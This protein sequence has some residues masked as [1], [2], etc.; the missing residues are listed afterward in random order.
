MKSI[1]FSLA[2]AATLLLVPLGCGDT[3]TVVVEPLYV[4]NWAPTQGSLCVD[5]DATL[6]VTF[7]DDIDVA[8]LQNGV[9]LRDA[10][11]EVAGV[12]DYSKQTF[13]ASYA[14][15]AAMAFDALYTLTLAPSLRGARLG[16]LGVALTSS[17]RTVARQGCSPGI[18]CQLPSDC[19]DGEICSN[20]GTCIAECVTDLDCQQGTCVDGSCVVN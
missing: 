8:T 20:I 16:D 4:V 12:I 15:T 9:T 14:P 1:A 6:Y 3:A 19:A 5:P 2:A 18:E 17:F 13:T 7:S 10:S 11:G